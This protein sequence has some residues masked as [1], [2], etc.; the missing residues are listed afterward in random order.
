MIGPFASIVPALPQ[1]LDPLNQAALDKPAVL[2]RPIN[3][4]STPQSPPSSLN[5]SRLNSTKLENKNRFRATRL[6]PLYPA[7]RFHRPILCRQS[8]TILSR[9]QFDTEKTAYGRIP[10]Y[11]SGE[12]AVRLEESLSERTLD[13]PVVIAVDPSV[14]SSFACS[15]KTI[16][17]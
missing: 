13:P 8:C 7:N 10:G 16:H 6:N 12:V 15:L 2:D 5:F 4:P 14:Y 1:K 11:C 17:T 9:S 3:A